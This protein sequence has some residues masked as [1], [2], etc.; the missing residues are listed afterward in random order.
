MSDIKFPPLVQDG[1]FKAWASSMRAYLVIQ[2]RL[3]KML[4][5]E[6]TAGDAKELES[7]IVCKAQLQLRVAGPLKAIFERAK[8][9]KEAWD[10]LRSE[11]V[12]S[13]QVRQPQLMAALTELR[14]GSLTLVQ[15]VS[16]VKQI[17]DE[18]E[19]LEMK[20]SLPLLSQRFIT[21]LSDELR[22][23]C[24]PM[25]HSF[26]LDKTKTLDDL[27]EQVR[28]MASLLPPS[29]AS[30]NTTRAYP[31]TS[32]LPHQRTDTRKCN[33]CHLKGHVEAEC[34]TK[35]CDQ[36][37]G[38]YRGHSRQKRQQTSKFPKDKFSNATVLC[39][40]AQS[41][42][43]TLSTADE[44]ALWYDTMATQHIVC[45][46]GL[47]ANHR[48]SSIRTVVLGGNEK[49]SVPCE[50]DLIV[51]GG[52]N[53]PVLFTNVLCVPTLQL[54]I[55]LCSGPQFT[56]KGGESWQGGNSYKLL[57]WKKELLTG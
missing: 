36:A 39:V 13:L 50:G 19:A 29:Y 44:S 41:H 6:P 53:G 8:T 34:R 51:T 25:L 40:E 35:R 43:F 42:A 23:S 28:S 22:I 11:Y 52:P 26:L 57:L 47:L 32:L 37:N 16:N 5:A 21:G 18:F 48:T 1:D 14:Q 17:R 55:N 27:I 3:D 15:Y 30:A 20:A 31:S 49:H 4:D 45:H 24:G 56:N 10:A 12:G 33:Y 2:Q 54:H 38:T 7:D 46:E 9:A